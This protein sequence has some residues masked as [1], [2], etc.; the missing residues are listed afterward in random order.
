M[1]GILSREEK[2]KKV[3][4]SQLIIGLILILVMVFGTVGYAFSDKSDENPEKIEYNSVKFIKANEYWNFNLN[5][6]S[7][8]TKY[9]PKEVENI[10]LVS[11]LSINSYTNKPL[12]IVSDSNEPN[13]EISRNLNPFVLRIQN[14][15]IS[16]ED[17]IGNLPVKN[18][19][20]DNVIIIKEP[21]TEGITESIFQ[22]DNCIFIT[23]SIE[24]QTRYAD[25]F[26]FK[27]LG[28]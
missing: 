6:N 22:Q 18:C 17:C 7:F 15:C 13:Y 4:R 25:V 1:K 5:G 21:K 24:N 27:I 14:S 19:S 20:E 8:I 16:E 26:L 2:G 9:N 3:R 28:I 11:Y 23:S 10:T 12:Y